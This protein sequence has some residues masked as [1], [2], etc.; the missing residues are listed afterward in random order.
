M[1]QNCLTY[2]TTT[3][4]ELDNRNKKNYNCYVDVIKVY[5]V[6]MEVVMMT[7]F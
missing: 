3:W 5:A 7:A 2:I 6:I 1:G 4:I